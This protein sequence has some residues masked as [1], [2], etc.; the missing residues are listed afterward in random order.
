MRPEE[1]PERGLPT[2]EGGVGL[3]LCFRNRGGGGRQG[4][5]AACVALLLQLSR[6]GVSDSVTPWTVAHQAF[7]S[8]TISH[9]LLRLMFMESVMPSKPLI[10]CRPLLPPLRNWGLEMGEQLAAA[11]VWR[12]RS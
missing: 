7:L 4:P 2:K 6:S 12:L 11:P 9:S 10:L 3:Q 8:F 5:Q 1:P